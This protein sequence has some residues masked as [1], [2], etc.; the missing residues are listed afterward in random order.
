MSAV[1]TGNTPLWRVLGLVHKVKQ[2]KNG[3]E[4]SCPGPNHKRGDRDPSLSVSM[5]LD[6]RVLLRCFGGCST[7]DILAAI[8]L[9]WSDLF[10]KSEAG[11]PVRR[12]QLLNNKGIVVAQHVREDVPGDKLIHWERNGKRTLGGLK[13]EDLPL[14]RLTDLLAT[15]DPSVPVIVCEGEKAAQ[16]LADAGVL[17]VATVTGASTIPS[18]TVL[19]PLQGRTNVRMWADNDDQGLT[20]MQKIAA[21]LRPAPKWIKWSGAPAHGDA[22]DYLAQGGDPAAIEQMVAMTDVQVGPRIWRASEL[23]AMRFEPVRWAIPGLVPTGLSILAGRPKLGKSWLGLGW[24]ID[25]SA[26][27]GALGGKMPKS[28]GEVLYMALEDGAQRM[29][30]RLAMMLGDKRP[31]DD[32]NIV[33]EWSRTNEGGIED[34][35]TWLETHPG[36]RLVVVDTFKRIRPKEKGNQRLYDLDYDAIAPLA[37]LARDRRVAIVVVFHT[38]KGDSPDPLEMVSGTLGLSGAADAVMVLRRERG[39]ADASLFV[40]GR[41]VEEQDL[42]LRWQKEEDF[43]WTLLG[44]A[45]DFR[46]SRERQEIL[47]SVAAMPGM[48][49]RE[50]AD[51]L[52]KASGAVRYLLFA[53][54]RDSELRV[55]DGK[56]YPRTN[57]NSPNSTSNGHT[58]ATSVS[59]SVISVVSAVRATCRRCGRSEAVHGEDDPIRCR[60]YSDEGLPGSA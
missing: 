22:A 42:A 28:Q 52:G 4:A 60:W 48:T 5:G 46:R 32:L 29:Q 50:V 41:D 17:A 26:G 8:D 6:G 56:Y 43:G 49:P 25:V 36:A 20:H 44:N 55:R 15:S 27:I 37:A 19:E 58:S 3:W 13:L 14:Y 33:T 10:E 40:T 53:M 35:S 38:R 12:F 30:E 57:A 34:L 11:N 16:A 47:D 1:Q 18:D 24:G 9:E 2:T 51:A 23:M 39:Q 7:E 45:E 31:P 21:R 59:N 54:V